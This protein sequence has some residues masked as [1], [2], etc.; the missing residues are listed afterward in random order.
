APVLGEIA[1]QFA[2]GQT[3]TFNLTPFSLAR[4]SS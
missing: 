3:S 2:Q 1:S 4:F